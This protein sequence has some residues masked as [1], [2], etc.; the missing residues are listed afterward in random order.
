MVTVDS[1]VSITQHMHSLFFPLG[2][3][4]VSDPITVVL[5]GMHL[6]ALV[7]VVVVR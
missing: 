4:N 6:Y 1:T 2:R 5:H 7:V 3:E